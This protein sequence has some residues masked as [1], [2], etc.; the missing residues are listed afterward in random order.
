[1]GISRD[2]THKRRATGGKRKSIRMKRK[3]E[4]GRQPAMTKV[5]TRSV[6]E[7]RCRGGNMKF[8]AMRLDAGNFA[9][10]S[11][12]ATRKTRLLNVVYNAS[13]NELVRTNTL[14]KSCIVQIDA[15]PFRQWYKQHYGVDLA[16]KKDTTTEE[17]KKSKNVVKKLAA[18]SKGHK[19]ETALAEQFSAGRLLAIITSRPGQSGRADG[20]ILEGPELEFYNKKIYR[21]KR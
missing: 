14:V 1:M 18:R 5:G 15:T 4:M 3:F 10:G 19:L 21:R 20:H 7:V 9:W 16:K 12:Q 8:R 17:A 11:E 2:S 13:N 6:H